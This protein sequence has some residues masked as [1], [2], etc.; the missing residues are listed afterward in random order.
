MT[1]FKVMSSH[2]PAMKKEIHKHT[3]PVM[4]KGQI[5]CFLDK[6][7]LTAFS[8]HQ[9]TQQTWKFITDNSGG[10]GKEQLRIHFAS[11][12]IQAEHKPVQV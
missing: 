10:S 11:S 7:L 3:K 6:L 8:F 4:A 5:I 1:Y 12:K 9:P 2:M